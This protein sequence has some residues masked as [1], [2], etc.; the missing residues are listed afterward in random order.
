VAHFDPTP[1]RA[2]TWEEQVTIMRRNSV[3]QIMIG[4]RHT[5]TVDGAIRA[6]R[7]E[8]AGL[9]RPLVLQACERR[10]EELRGTERDGGLGMKIQVTGA[11]AVDPDQK[12]WERDH[13]DET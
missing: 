2:V 13:H 1:R 6:Q 5:E 4:L 12:Q 10:V 7:A 8:L 3:L 9:C 11:E